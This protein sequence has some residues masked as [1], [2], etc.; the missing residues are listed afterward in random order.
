M[1]RWCDRTQRNPSAMPLRTKQQQKTV[2]IYKHSKIAKKIF[3]L[4]GLQYN[5]LNSLA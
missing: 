2:S 5:G 3:Q 4:T 1:G